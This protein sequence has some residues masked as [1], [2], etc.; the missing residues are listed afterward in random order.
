M[1]G[2]GADLFKSVGVAFPKEEV[3]HGSDW[4]GG[5]TALLNNVLLLLV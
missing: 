4:E 2:G 1:G 3:G 5:A